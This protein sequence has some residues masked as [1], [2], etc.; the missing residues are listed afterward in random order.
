[1][2]IDILKEYLHEYSGNIMIFSGILLLVVGLLY[3]DTWGSP[4]SVVAFFFGIVLFT[5]GLFAR[6]GLFS[7]K[8]LS[9]NG[10][11]TILICVSVAFLALCF[12]VTEFQAVASVV[13]VYQMGPG[14]KVIPYQ[15][16]ITYRP[17]VWLSF[18]LIEVGLPL[19]FAGL[20][21]KAYSAR[22]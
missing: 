20:I 18:N 3:V 7:L 4:V 6:V 12:A 5:F 15:E 9:L 21:A 19:L 8:L 22:R 17:Y 14:G 2:A 1:M 10:L 11:G 13:T 16:V